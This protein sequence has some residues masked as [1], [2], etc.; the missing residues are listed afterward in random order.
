MG[1]KALI[2]DLDGTAIPISFDGVPSKAVIDAVSKAQEKIIVSCATGRRLHFAKNIIQVFKLRAPCII[3]GGTQI[4]D[5][6]DFKEMWSHTMS[7]NQIRSVVD[8]FKQYDYKLWVGDS[9]ELQYPKDILQF[10]DKHVIYAWAVTLDDSRIIMDKLRNI[11]DIN[12]F[13]V[14]SWT[15]GFVDVHVLH[16]EATKEHAMNKWLE[17]MNLKKKEVIAVGDSS[18]DIPLF[19][20]A[21]L[22]VAMSNASDELKAQADYIAPSVDEDGLVDVIQKYIL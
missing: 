2:F 10:H 19:K 18:N 1:Y 4:I 13:E 16:Q 6:S 22:K 7:S 20:S 5:P 12:V 21:G 3:S 8:V 14:P 17:I 11:E 9:T 15:K